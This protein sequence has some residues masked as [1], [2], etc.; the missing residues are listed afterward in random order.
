[1]K[2]GFFKEGKLVDTCYA[3]SK[4]SASGTKEIPVFNATS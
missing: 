3:D 4:I 2:F 1:M